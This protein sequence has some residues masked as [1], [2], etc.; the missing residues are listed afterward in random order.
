MIKREYESRILVIDD[1]ESICEIVRRFL[2]NDGYDV[3]TRNSVSSGMELILEGEIDLVLVDL[4][5]P[6][7]S[8][9]ELVKELKGKKLALEVIVMSG[10]G[11]VENAVEAIKYGA[12]DFIEKPINFKKLNVSIKNALEKRNLSNRLGFLEAKVKGDVEFSSIIGNESALLKVISMAKQV[13][14]SDVNLLVTGESGTGKEVFVKAIHYAGHR[15]KGPF[16]AINCAAIPENLLESELFGYE[17]G[18]FTGADARKIGYFESADDG[19]IFLDEVNELPLTLQAKVLR[20]I[21]EKKIT[22]LGSTKEIPVN[23]RIISA[24]NRNLEALI[25]G[26]QFREDLFYRLGVIEIKLP[27]LR[28]RINDVP[29]LI[30]HFLKKYNAADMRIDK[31]ALEQML[32]YSWPGNIRELENVVQRAIILTNQKVITIDELPDKIFKEEFIINF[33][34]DQTTYQEF[35]HEVELHEKAF[36]SRVIN[37]CSGNVAKTAKEIGISRQSLH[38]NLK[39]YEIEYKNEKV[40]HLSGHE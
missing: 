34:E 24:T 1:E 33:K 30:E 10:H 31:K 17:K 26:G 22:R 13:A 12:Y 40:E 16:I 19:T 11:T 14:G 39:K 3:C 20:A 32:K 23:C 21:Q 28:D 18:A 37:N 9:I 15:G 38:S 4:M 2:E 8:G 6:E 7:I 29:F 35:K 27:P 25:E 36:F 5:L